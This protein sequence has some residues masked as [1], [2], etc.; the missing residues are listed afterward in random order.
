VPLDDTF[1]AWGNFALSLEVECSSLGLAREVEK[2]LED[3]P[4]ERGSP[5]GAVLA[6]GG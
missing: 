6:A 2:C 5:V 3:G 4:R 1:P